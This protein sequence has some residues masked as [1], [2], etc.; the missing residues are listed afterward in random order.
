MTVTTEHVYDCTTL[1]T[2]TVH[3]INR[4]QVDKVHLA[5][6]VPVSAPAHTHRTDWKQEIQLDRPPDALWLAV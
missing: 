4:K 6:A 5:A 1:H 3:T 2:S